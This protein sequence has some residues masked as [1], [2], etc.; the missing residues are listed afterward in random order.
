MKIMEAKGRLTTCLIF[1]FRCHPNYG[2]DL[3]KQYKQILYEI[4]KSELLL[5]IIR[6][7]L[8]DQDFVP[9]MGMDPKLVLESNYA[10]S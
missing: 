1:G 9:Y 3:R 4:A 7:I 10:L 8:P 5:S 6:Q 2:N